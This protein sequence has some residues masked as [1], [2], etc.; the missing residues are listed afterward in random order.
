MGH[1]INPLT[2]EYIS[3]RNYD[4]AITVGFIVQPKS[5][6]DTAIWPDLETIAFFAIFDFV[7]LA[8]IN[9]TLIQFLTVLKNKTIALP[10]YSNLFFLLL[11]K[12][13]GTELAL[14]LNNFTDDRPRYQIDFIHINLMSFT[15]FDQRYKL[16][17][18][19]AASYQ[20][21][22]DDCCEF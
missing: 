16:E 19:I 18:L 10:I 6:V 11:G 14:F 22:F 9:L 21:S 20:K 17:F 8:R 4:A 5:F 1:V 13:E 15:V 2:F 3:V 12:S 7:P